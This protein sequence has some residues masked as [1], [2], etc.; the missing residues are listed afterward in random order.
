MRLPEAVERVMRSVL[1]REGH[2]PSA[3]RRAAANRAQALCGR[4]PGESELP[5]PLE[6]YVDKVSRTPY[7]VVGADLDALRAAGHSEDEIF[8]LTVATALGSA[9]GR[10]ARVAAL[11]GEKR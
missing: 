1:G 8:E 7:K 6:G 3:L 2:A 9:H 10:F 5:G 11:L 4:D